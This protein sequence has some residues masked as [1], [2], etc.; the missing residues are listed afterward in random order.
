MLRSKLRIVFF[1]S[2]IEER[3][4][5]YSNKRNLCV[6]HLKKKLKRLLK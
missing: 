6:T 2:R 5:R 1:K 4:Q 3:K